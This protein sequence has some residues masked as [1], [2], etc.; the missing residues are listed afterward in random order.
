MG[1]IRHHIFSSLQ[2][3][4][5]ATLL[6][7]CGISRQT[8]QAA[9]LANC[10]FKIVSA[11]NISLGGVSLQN[12][13]SVSDLNLGDMARLMAGVASPVL[14]LTLTL[15]L[16]GRNPNSKPA[17]MNRLEWIFFVDDVQ[18]A[19]GI[20]EKPFLIPP[21]NGTA[22]I[23]VDVGLDLKKALT[24]ESSQAML[25][26]ALNLSG[27]GNKPTRFKVKIKPSIVVGG[28]TLNFPGFITI[29]TDYAGG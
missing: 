5:I 18:M 2:I 12:I 17:G 21:N 14:P 1:I 27:I 3:M 7:A 20:L 8:Q 6:S 15:N 11:E 28:S 23:P 26:L 29:K 13:H 9:S 10:E 24:G 16:Q 19:S 25:N 4:L 22:I